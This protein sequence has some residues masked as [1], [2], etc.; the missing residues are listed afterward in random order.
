MPARHNKQSS[1]WGKNPHTSGG[2]FISPKIFALIY[3]AAGIAWIVLSD[4]SVFVGLAEAPKETLFAQL[5]KG[6]FFII[7]TTAL[8]YWLARQAQQQM[9]QKL[10][11]EELSTS[12]NI[13]K[14]LLSSLGEA[15]LVIEPSNRTIVQC[16]PAA[17]R[18]FGYSREELLGQNTQMLH[19]SNQVYEEFGR[20]GEPIL[21]EFGVYKTEQRMRKKDASL[22]ETEITVTA[23][24]E[25]LGWQGGVISIIRDI[26]ARKTAERE[27][28]ESRK[29]YRNL[30]EGT[31]DLITR[32]DT[33]GRLIFVNHAANKFF[34]LSE[35]DCIGQ[36]AFDFIHP[37]DRESTQSA[38]TEWLNQEEEVFFHE[39]RLLSINGQEFSVTWS[40]HAEYDES[41]KL[42][43]F[44]S[45][46][47]DITASK[48]NQKERESLE[49]LLHQAQKMEAI[50]HLA[51][52]IA[53]DFNN[54]LGVILG[55]AELVLKKSAPSSSATSN[56]KEIRRAA[57][58]SA[59][60]TRQ[61][62]T[63]AR[64][65]TIQPKV[66][67]IN[68]LVS[69]M[70]KM[71]QRL[72]G[73]NIHIAW[74]PASSL[75]PVKIDPTQFDQILTNLCLN[76][77]DAIS[78]AGTIT[79]KT[80]NSKLDENDRIDHPEIIPGDYVLLRISDEGSGMDQDTL[81]HIFDPFFTTKDVGLGT[82][83]GL[84]TVLGAVKQNDGY[85][86]AL[87]EQGQGTIFNIYLPR[88]EGT[89]QINPEPENI[90][91]RGGTE[92]ILLVEDDSMLLQLTKSMLEENGYKVLAAATTDLAQTLA[93]EHLGKID[94]LITD[95]IMPGMNGKELSE[96]LLWKFPG[97][98]II[99]MSGYS[100][101]I[102]SSHGI[103]HDGIT[104][105]QKPIS[106]DTL[107]KTVRDTLDA[108]K[109]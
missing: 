19:E 22:I 32:V 34:G 71:L 7:I 49:S 107:G 38:F 103:V 43:G 57:N 53:H 18:L 67:N 82:G 89:I 99:F 52:G 21:S 11:I 95:V 59:D 44:A 85:I 45:T 27:L 94:L 65:Q 4:L 46:A 37:E 28:L 70:L 20:H 47:R 39:N 26:T 61:L 78:G 75:W 15:V 31:P 98:K 2:L 23:L 6:S 30:V 55:H 76:A 102:I 36:V 48:K 50:G 80:A 105:L 100:Q 97:I 35:T 92:T 108:P 14:V 74:H 33:E 10:V 79:I 3:A 81:N 87:S 64:K 106:L 24:N 88:E 8:V 104:L 12:Q 56:L 5:L 69:G 72:I 51:G 86:Y 54:M 101:N 84:A 13:L 93:H 29:Q 25:E 17:E 40:I 63:F 62:L 68:E 90:S 83:L 91:V 41:G 58:R 109:Q 73:E 1:Y 66:L 42:S 96:K 16:N 77:R 60:L 9:R